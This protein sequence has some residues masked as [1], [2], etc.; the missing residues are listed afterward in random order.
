MKSLRSFALLML[1]TLSPVV[2]WPEESKRPAEDL[3]ALVSSAL[4][5]NPELKSSQA[6]WQ[7]FVNKA[8]QASSLED[9]MVMFKLQNMLVREPFVFNKDP[10]S[11]KVIGISQQ[12]PFWGKQ[13]IKQEIAD[14]EAESYK[15][16]IE[17]RKLELTR[18]VKETYYQIWAKDKFLA[19][20]DKNLQL[21]GDIK[22]I[23][24]SKYSV[25]QGVQQDIYKAGL[26]KS[27]M[28]DMQITLRQQR[29]SL[30]ANLNYLLYRPGTTPIGTIPD[31]TLPQLSQTAEQLN[32]TALQKRPQFKSL[33]QL[34]NK[35]QATHRLAQKEFYPD[36]NLSFE[37]MFKDKV[38]T[39]MVNDPGYDMFTVGVTFNLPFQHERR[40]AMVAESTSETSMATEEQ[41]ALKNAISYTIN[42]TLAQLD[43]RKKLI[44]LY[45][46]GIISQAEQS[47]ES[48]VISY[49]VNKV[50][51]LTLLDGRM[52]L[53]NYERELFESQAEYMMK[54]AQLEATVG[55]DLLSVSTAQIPLPADVQVKPQTEPVVPVQPATVP[56]GDHSQHH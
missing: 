29:S 2:A 43:R 45:K 41:N 7:M 15:W 31:F 52:T 24:E 33:T 39:D 49:R 51:F 26:E 17:E 3:S 4:A 13:A 10:Q 25:G 8:K 23:A 37:Y 30:E 44:D 28:L 46:G 35:G 9:P 22:T 20:I 14:Y 34:I 47:L 40:Q 6:K 12:I 11:A 5:G 53:F 50:D 18:M 19:I 55:T 38:S 1:L 27:K 42:D 32:A 16:S 54:L 48:A 36:F 56:V 21:L